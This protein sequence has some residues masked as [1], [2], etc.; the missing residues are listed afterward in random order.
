MLN[1]ATK[2][3]Y[4]KEDTSVSNKHGFLTRLSENPVHY[5]IVKPAVVGL[6]P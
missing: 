1:N 2:G 5:I 3:D 6:D 4:M